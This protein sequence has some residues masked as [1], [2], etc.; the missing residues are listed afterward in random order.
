MGVN[1]E[2]AKEQYYLPKTFITAKGC[3]E[4]FVQRSGS[5]HFWLMDYFQVSLN[6]RGLKSLMGMKTRMF[7]N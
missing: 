3:K 7:G 2:R 4:L 6:I 1:P 5:Q